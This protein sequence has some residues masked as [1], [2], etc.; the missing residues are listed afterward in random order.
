MARDFYE[1]LDVSR[2]ASKED[3]KRSYR[4]L[5]RQFHP[6]VNKESG[7]EERFKDICRA[8]EILADD[9]LRSRYDRFGEAGLNG[10]GAAGFDSSGGFGDI[11]DI[12]E[13]FFGGFAGGATARRGGPMRGD[14]LR[15]D[16]TLEFKEAIFG[17]EREISI[18][19][20]VT[21]DTCRGAG[22]KAGSGPV[23]CRT[24]S[25]QGQVRQA[26]R[27]PFG[28]FT[29]VTAC[30]TCSG[31]GEIIENPCPTCNGRGRVQ[32]S[33]TIKITLPAGVDSGT[34][35]R[36]QGE[37]DAG[38]RGGPSGDLYVYLSVRPHPVFRR[39]GNDLSSIVEVTYLQ[40]ILGTTLKVETVEGFQDVDIPAGTQ[41]ETV[42]T[43]DGKGVPRLGNSTRRGN[44]YLL[45]KVIIPNKVSGEERELLD[46]LA[47]LRDE[48][49][50]KKEGLEGLLDSIGNLF[51]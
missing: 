46:K 26:R 9:E 19:H 45:I 4:K 40:A 51:H 21:C 1:T 41:P 3:I 50:A 8:Y 37:G 42:L 2:D 23:T 49:I 24:C 18:D 27:T 30:P 44:H 35:L 6:D 36:V 43:L 7:A 47:S 14:D 31:T 29:Q 28:L 5:A 20:L 15:F 34:R 12:F 48:K 39:D 10:A 13:S 17:G 38:L 22:T 33:T 16:L 11:G 25:G 32:R